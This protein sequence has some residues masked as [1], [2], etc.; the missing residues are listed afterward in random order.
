MALETLT[1]DALR[2]QAVLFAQEETAHKEPALYGVTDGKAIGTYIERKFSLLLAKSYDL[3]LGN[4]AKGIDLPSVNVDVKVTSIAKPQSSCPFSSARQKIFGL[5]YSLLVFVYEKSDDAAANTSTL[6]I[7][8]TI[9]IDA[10]V[11]GDFTVTKRL[12]EMVGDGANQEDIV[13][14]LQDRNLPADE[15]EIY[16][17][18]AS[19][20]ASTPAQGYLTVSNAHQWRLAYDRAINAAGEVAGI[21]RL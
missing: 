9:F 8:H 1:L 14:Y 5:G 4:A 6:S 20:L 17:I 11:T 2:E 3:L 15:I 21:I 7:V 19:V 13:G 12:R 10:A 18:A 16:S